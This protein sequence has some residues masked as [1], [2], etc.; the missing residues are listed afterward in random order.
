[1]VHRTPSI[2]TAEL[3]ASGQAGDTFTYR[4]ERRDGTVVTGTSGMFQPS[5]RA[6]VTARQSADRGSVA[7]ISR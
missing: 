7:T 3:T 5:R 6:A 2:P 1:M 4:I